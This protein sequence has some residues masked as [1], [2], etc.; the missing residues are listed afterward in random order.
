M[1]VMISESEKIRLKNIPVERVAEALGLDVTRHHCLCFGHDDHHP[2]LVFNVRNNTW[3]CYACG[4]YGDS[5]SLVQQK[6]GVGFV[7]ACSWLGARFGIMINNDEGAV[8]VVVPKPAAQS[9]PAAKEKDEAAAPDVEVL[10]YVSVKCKYR[11]AD[12]D[13]FLYRERHYKR[14]V[15]EKLNIGFVGLY[16]GMAKAIVEKFGE[17][18]ALKSGM[19][20]K[21]GGRYVFAFN[22]PC[23][24]FSYM[25][26][27]GKLL[28]LQ[29]RY[30]GDEDKS[31]FQF[32]R[33]CKP[34][35][36]NQPILNEIEEG[37]E[38]YVSEGVT[39]CISLMSD[40]FKAI[41]VP[42]ATL[43]KDSDADILARYSLKM[44]P[45][46]DEPG[47]RLFNRLKE[48]VEERG[49]K[50]ECLP[51]PD[52]MKDYSD[53]YIYKQSKPQ[54]A[55]GSRAEEKAQSQPTTYLRKN[56]KGMEL[57]INT[58]GT[59]LN[60]DNEA[61]LVSNTEGRQRIPV[62]GIK[63]IHVGRGVQVTSDAIML[64]IEHEIEMSFTDKAG[65]P[66]GRVWSPK[67]GS[68]ST[69]RKGQLNFTFTHDSLVWIKDVIIK[70]IENQQALILM[71]EADSDEMK[72][73][74]NKAITRLEDYRNK[75]RS[76]EG[77]IV[78]DVAPSLRG[79]EGQASKVYFDALNMFLPEDLRFEVRSQR[80]AM[81]VVN[82]FLNYGYGVMYGRIE[83]ALIKAGID[84][85]VGVL[86][87]DD[88]N[89][90]VLVYDVIELYRVWVDYVVYNLATQGVVT[91]DYYSVKEDGS[92]WLENLGRRVLIQS[93]ND[94]LEEV[95]SVGSLQRS[96]STQIQ[97]YA[98]KLAQVFK[99]AL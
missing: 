39:D 4:I 84:P 96:R 98:H 30:I 60:R 20:Y 13:R 70:K 67:Y 18:R 12:F 72:G 90:P 24:I 11:S 36:F 6:L 79:W 29:A 64:A 99:N 1:S 78:A 53:Y 44:Y 41:A 54:E 40:G 22:A 55:D 52:G 85:Y 77:D 43:L 68:V 33:G 97:M 32:P 63:A 83:G 86:H 71:F 61:F 62:D 93:L 23:L 46:Q 95:V 51:L 3:K 65:R 31:R 45:D 28:S 47:M 94:Y 82:A 59:S 73:R 5:I 91:E 81:D 34:C 69:I 88:Y 38:L 89:R 75:I 87:R 92:Y 14:A 26:R 48:K 10:E 76:L 35:I 19:V 27:D 42:S 15:V 7:D 9:R 80:P 8:P 50:I 74:V 66:V 49:G 37:D 56:G 2:S 25:G 58:F 21:S 17:Q 57:I 16:N